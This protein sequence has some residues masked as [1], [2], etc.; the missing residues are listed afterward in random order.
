LTV[1]WE[2]RVVLLSGLLQNFLIF[3]SAGLIAVNVGFFAALARISRHR[4]LR[5]IGTFHVEIFRNIP[6]YML[7]IWVYVVMPL[8]LSYLL[9]TRVTILPFVAAVIAIGFAYSGYFAETFR[10][11]ILSV[12]RGHVDA[13]Y[14]VGLSMAQT[15][16]R[17][18]LPQAIRRVLPESLSIFVSLF[19]ATTIVS[20]IS[21]NDLLYRVNLVAMAETR[22]LPLYTGAALTYFVVVLIFST[23]VQTLT[24]RWR[25]RGWT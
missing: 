16:V 2:Y 8:L 17:V 15:M 23:S 19:K 4:A 21:V 3:L 6:E 7:L 22:P 20:L 25:R 11:G 14:A 13:A 9:G 12:P 24:N 18:I 10:A 5:L 1:F